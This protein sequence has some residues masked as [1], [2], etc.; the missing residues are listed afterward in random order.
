MTT[1]YSDTNQRPPSINEADSR[2]KVRYS[3]LN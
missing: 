3:H 2:H 1:D